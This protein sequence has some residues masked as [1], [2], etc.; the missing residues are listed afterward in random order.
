MMSN[1]VHDSFE[2]EKRMSTSVAGAGKF[3]SVV[4]GGAG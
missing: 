1:L 3:V 4:L 2:M